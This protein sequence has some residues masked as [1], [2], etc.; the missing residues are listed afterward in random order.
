MSF[1]KIF[2]LTAGVYFD[3]HNILFY[4]CVWSY[5]TPG[6]YEIYEGWARLAKIFLGVCT[7]CTE[8]LQQDR[9]ITDVRTINQSIPGGSKLGDMV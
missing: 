5:L 8:S 7:G 2:D 6:V 1:D 9:V 4:S 3:F